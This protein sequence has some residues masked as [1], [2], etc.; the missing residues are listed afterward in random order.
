[1]SAPACVLTV[2]AF[3]VRLKIRILFKSLNHSS[4]TPPSPI[5]YPLPIK[6]TFPSFL[7]SNEPKLLILT[8]SLCN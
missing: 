3:H 1:M 7:I 6:P 2:I 8:S 4:P 5:P